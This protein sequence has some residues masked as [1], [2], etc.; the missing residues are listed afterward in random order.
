VVTIALSK[1]TIPQRKELKDLCQETLIRKLSQ[2]ESFEFVSKKLK[3]AGLVFDISF[4]YVQQLRSEIGKSAKSE[5]L[6]LQKDRYALIQ[7]LFFDRKD[8]LI[9][10]QRVLWQIVESNKL[11]PEIQIKAIDKL[12]DLNMA[13]A[14][15]YHSLPSTVSFGAK[16]WKFVYDGDN[17]L[18]FGE[19]YNEDYQ[20]AARRLDYRREIEA[21]AEYDREFAELKKNNP[22]WSDQRIGSSTF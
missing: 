18:H 5:L 12:Q 2:K 7:S 14:E 13:L 1:L 16:P 8:E 20:E 3:S 9:E 11:N 4:D 17:S 22:T 19:P 10:M 21:Q 15:L 6:T